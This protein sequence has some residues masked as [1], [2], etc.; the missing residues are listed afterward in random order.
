MSETEPT[1]RFCKQSFIRTQPAT[2]KHLL[3]CRSGT[4]QVQKRQWAAK[5]IESMS[6]PEL[7]QASHQEGTQRSQVT[8]AYKTIWCF[9]KWK[10]NELIKGY[11]KM[12][13]VFKPI[14]K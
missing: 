4:E 8:I 10:L 13:Q 11:I 9:L 1:A 5:P 14:T 6:V 2:L 7:F 3:P 12:L